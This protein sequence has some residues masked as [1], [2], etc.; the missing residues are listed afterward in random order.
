MQTS[1][2]KERGVWGIPMTAGV[3]MIIGGAFALCAALLTSFVS[4]F[5]I[6]GSLIVVGVLELVA[7]F[8]LRDRGPTIALAAAGIFAVL[9]GVLLLARPLQGLMSLTLLLAG[10]LFASGLFRG[11][12]AIGDRYPGWGW[13]VAY[14]LVSILL[15]SYVAASW[16]ISSLWVL[17]TVVGVEIIARGVS[18]VA[19]SFAMRDVEHDVALFAR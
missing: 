19:A 14:G 18:L 3:L 15:G 16:P 7:G 9:A 10:Y 4:V 8:R 12:T 13:D 6:A 5:Y 1:R 17:G 11:I 2:S